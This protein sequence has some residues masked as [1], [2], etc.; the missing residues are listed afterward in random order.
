MYHKGWP[1]AL[2]LNLETN[3]F[4]VARNYKYKETDCTSFVKSSLKSHVFWVTLCV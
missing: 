4:T 2:N 3:K 1:E